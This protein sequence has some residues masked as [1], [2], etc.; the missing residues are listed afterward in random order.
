MKI[1]LLLLAHRCFYN[2]LIMAVLLEIRS[3]LC[4]QAA[5]SINQAVKVSYEP[6][7]VRSL[8]SGKVGCLEVVSEVGCSKKLT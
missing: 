2:L 4:V 8:L 1:P 3:F 6:D 7:K 5:G